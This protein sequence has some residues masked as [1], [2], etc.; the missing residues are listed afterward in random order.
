[1][2]TQ[3]LGANV[4]KEELHR[5][6]RHVFHSGDKMQNLMELY[7]EKY[8]KRVTIYDKRIV[9]DVYLAQSPNDFDLMEECILKYEYYNRPN[10]WTLG[11]DDDKQLMAE[12]MSCF[13]SK[14]ALEIGCSTGA[15]IQCLSSRGIYCEGIE[16]SQLATENAFPSIKNQIHYGDLLNLHLNDKYNLIFGLDIFEHLNPIKIE[17]YIKE[18]YRILS[19]G[20]FV[21]ANIPAFGKDPVFGEIFPIYILDWIA[22]AAHNK[23]FSVLH[24][25]SLGYPLHGHLIWAHTNWWTSVFE[26]NGLIRIPKLEQAFHE[27]DQLIASNARKSFYIF[28]KNYEKYG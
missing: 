3:Q 27:Y 17:K 23:C 5:N 1:M 12:I 13:K 11:M 25:D 24:V 9:H 6:H 18:I 10:C 7:P 20:G 2:S 19:P 16:I 26:K 15:V 22:D 14:S 8:S 28:R 4:D 21:F